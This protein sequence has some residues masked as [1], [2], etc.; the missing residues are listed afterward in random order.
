MQYRFAPGHKNV[1]SEIR[2]SVFQ[3]DFALG[4]EDELQK[5]VDHGWYNINETLDK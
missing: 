3:R 1:L 5:G 2:W 4:F